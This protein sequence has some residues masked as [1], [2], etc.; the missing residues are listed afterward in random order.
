MERSSPWTV[1]RDTGAINIGIDR[2]IQV[3]L[4]Y[5]PITR[6][7]FAPRTNFS[8]D[9]SAPGGS[10]TAP[11]T[12]SFRPLDY[13]C[14]GNDRRGRCRGKGAGFETPVVARTAFCTINRRFSPPSFTPSLISRE[15]G[16]PE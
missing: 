1:A 7:A 15:A 6:S 9:H 14:A 11:R 5:W 12:S 4:A 3:G 2:C 10:Q 13:A 8:V 16:R